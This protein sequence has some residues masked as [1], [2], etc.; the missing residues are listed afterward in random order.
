MHLILL[1]AFFAEIYFR[2]FNGYFKFSAGIIVL[3][4]I[5]LVVDDIPEYWLAI[6]SGFAV[7]A[8][9]TAVSLF[10]GELP[11]AALTLNL[12]SLAYYLAYGFLARILDIKK[13]QDQALAGIMLLSAVDFLSNLLEAA[14][15]IE[16]N[17]QAV[18]LIL[19]VAFTRSIVAYFIYEIYQRQKLFI[20]SAEHQKRYTQLNMFIANIQAE[21][22]YLKKSMKDIEEVMRKSYSLYEQQGLGAEAR[23]KALDIARGVHEIKKDY[24]RVLLGFE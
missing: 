22:F 4:L 13:R 5:L 8:V 16:M 15:R 12:P 17:A 7:F 2:P 6:F 19:L 14:L 11:S 24:Q 18:K 9:R 23:E 20:L 3:N 10:G 1:V 21:I